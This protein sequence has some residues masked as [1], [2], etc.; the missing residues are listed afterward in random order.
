MPRMVPAS[1]GSTS[2]PHLK[3]LQLLS[4]YFRSVG[5]FT[6]SKPGLPGQSVTIWT[7]SGDF[8]NAYATLQSQYN[9]HT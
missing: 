8:E 2:Y 3:V 1:V 4:S 7:L 9:V 6:N 5:T